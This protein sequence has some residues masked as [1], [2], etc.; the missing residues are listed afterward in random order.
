MGEEVGE[1]PAWACGLRPSWRTQSRR[2]CSWN[3]FSLAS[4]N[5]GFELEPGHKAAVRVHSTQELG[6]W[7]GSYIHHFLPS[8]LIPVWLDTKAF[9][10]LGKLVG[11]GVKSSLFPESLHAGACMILRESIS[12]LS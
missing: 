2:Q 11:V 3:H 7:P 4:T 12:G 6:H 10:G 5:E 1:S 9:K 8:P